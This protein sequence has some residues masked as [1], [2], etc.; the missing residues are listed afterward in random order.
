MKS[1]INE[2]RRKLSEQEK[3]ALEQNRIIS[4]QTIKLAGHESK[5]AEINRK[6]MEYDQRFSDKQMGNSSSTGGSWARDDSS[7]KQYYV[8]HGLP[9]PAMS[10]AVFVPA[11]IVSQSVVIFCF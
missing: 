2:M 10:P 9:T 6:L 7:S 1:K 5:F 4:E 3:V 8:S 11:N